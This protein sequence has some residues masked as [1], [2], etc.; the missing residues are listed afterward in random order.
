MDGNCP[1]AGRVRPGPHLAPLTPGARPALEVSRVAVQALGPEELSG[2]S[3]CQ[4]R[5]GCGGP[6][7]ERGGGTEASLVSASLSLE[8]SGSMFF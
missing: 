1:V 5:H 3:S 7:P 8:Q 6:S 2:C 4:P